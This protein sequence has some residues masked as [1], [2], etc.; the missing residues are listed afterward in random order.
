[1]RL[2]AA[3]SRGIKLRRAGPGLFALPA[4]IDYLSSLFFALGS[5]VKLVTVILVVTAINLFFFLVLGQFGFVSVQI[6]AANKSQEP[7]Q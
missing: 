7:E 4:T 6:G 3:L 1:M 5:C 2:M